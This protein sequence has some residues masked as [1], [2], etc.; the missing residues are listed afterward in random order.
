MPAVAKIGS[1]CTGH[2]GFP[3]RACDE[4]SADVFVNG[5]GVHRQGDHWTTHCRK[6]SCHDSTLASGSATVFV[7]GKP[8]GRVGDPIACGSVVAEGSDNVF[9]G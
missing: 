2:G 6:S 8:V 1:T 9:S 3:P 7:N 4:G 5:V